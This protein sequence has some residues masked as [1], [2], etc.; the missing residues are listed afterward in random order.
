MRSSSVRNRPEHEAEHW[1]AVLGGRCAAAGALF[2]RLARVVALVR[3]LLSLAASS[4]RIRSRSVLIARRD[5]ISGRR[6]VV[7]RRL[8]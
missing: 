2:P 6:R 7:R 8:L 3:S 1:K 4:S 5:A